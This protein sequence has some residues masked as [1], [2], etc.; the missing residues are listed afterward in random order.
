LARDGAQECGVWEERVSRAA[1]LLAD[2]RAGHRSITEIAFACGFSDNT[3]F[4]RVFA[5]RMGVTPTQ[6][7]PKSCRPVHLLPAANANG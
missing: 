3:H 4:G 7:R 6:W 5:T 2:P 1:K